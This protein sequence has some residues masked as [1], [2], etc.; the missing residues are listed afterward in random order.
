[1]TSCT[2][3]EKIMDALSLLDED[4]AEEVGRLRGRRPKKPSFMRYGMIA[5]GFCVTL[6]CVL[7][8]VPLMGRVPEDG[9]TGGGGQ[10]DVSLENA[11]TNN[12]LTDTGLGSISPTVS[13]SDEG[14]EGETAEDISASDESLG[15]GME[16]IGDE[17]P[18]LKVRIEGFDGELAYCTVVENVDTDIFPVG[19]NLFISFEKWKDA[20]YQKIK[21]EDLTVGMEICVMFTGYDGDTIFAVMLYETEE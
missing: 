4:M 3:S 17:K 12:S 1:M 20:D 16:G 8:L 7:Q 10:E 15:G 2:S 14:S 6:L 18:S 11:G 21:P 9:V 13:E 5:A 19:T